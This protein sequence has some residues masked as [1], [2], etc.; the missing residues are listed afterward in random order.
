MVQKK[1]TRS[2]HDMFLEVARAKHC[3]GDHVRRS[4]AAVRRNQQSVNH[5]K[6][7][8]CGTHLSKTSLR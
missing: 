2:P 8:L 4:A 5:F 3:I 6:V 7:V 1:L